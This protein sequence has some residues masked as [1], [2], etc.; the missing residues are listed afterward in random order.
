AYMAPERFL[1]RRVT[2]AVDIY[3]L[4]CVLFETLTGRSPFPDDGMDVVIAAHI[5]TP[6]PRPSAVNP[7]VPPTFDEV[8][9]R[10]MAKDADDRYPTAGA[11]G[12]AAQRALRADWG[13]QPVAPTMPGPQHVSPSTAAPTWVPQRPAVPPTVPVP[14]RQH[15]PMMVMPPTTREAPSRSGKWVVP[16][17]I[18][19]AAIVVLGAIGVVIGV[20]KNS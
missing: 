4:A 16:T 18:A 7:H 12:R 1:D 13:A 6:P 3:A 5:S 2:T 17:V 11:L 14:P 19:V 9:A 15:D 10:G 20:L 8:I